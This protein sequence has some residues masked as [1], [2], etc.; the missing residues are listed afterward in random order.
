VELHECCGQGLLIVERLNNDLSG[1]IR[2]A[3]HAL[4]SATS[5]MT[6]MMVI[7]VI[8]FEF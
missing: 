8:I 5:S 4:M 7:I 1:I 6:L 3:N 2:F